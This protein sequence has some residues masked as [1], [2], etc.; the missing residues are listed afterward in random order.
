MKTF[1]KEN[2]TVKIFPNRD[3]M[4]LDAAK[5]VSKKINELL[6][7]KD[8][9]NMIFAAAPSQQDFM[10]HLTSDKSID[11]TRINAFHMDEYIGLDKSAP[12][13]FGNFLKER[14]FSKAPF[15][16]IHYID[17]EAVDPEKEAVRYAKLLE[18]YPV[19]IVCL[20]IGENGHIAFND[21]HV[22][23]FND[24]KR[25]KVVELDTAC[26]TQQVNEGQF[27][28][29]NLVPTQAI[30]ITIPGLLKAD[31]MFCMVPAE[32]KAV[33]VERTL[34]GEIN[35]ECPASILRTKENAVLYLDKASASLLN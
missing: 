2:L 3:E 22:A 5:D 14:L 20:G 32:N 19:D 13:A 29:L 7:N 25:V 33:A 10:A 18:K 30:T 24:P 27:T 9:L 8:E 23:D 1:K 35:E 12:Q 28:Q 4:G 21:P 17:V 11:W 26:R 6:A 16:S 34:N 31:S 15:K